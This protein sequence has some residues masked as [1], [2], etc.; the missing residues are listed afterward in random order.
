MLRVRMI[1]FGLVFAGIASAQ[2]DIAACMIVNNSGSYRL[3]SDLAS[4]DDCLTVSASNV[5]ID[6]N[7][8]SITGNCHVVILRCAGTA[9]TDGGIARRGV[10][11]RNGRLTNYVLG[12][13]LAASNAIRIENMDVI[14]MVSDAIDGGLY[15][16]VN[17]THALNNGLN[18]ISLGDNA[19]VTNSSANGNGST[20]ITVGANAIVTNSSANG[21]GYVTGT[22]TELIGHAGIVAGTGALISGNTANGNGFNNVFGV[23]GQGI[24]ALAGSQVTNNTSYGPGVSGSNA[25][26]GMVV[27]C[28]SNVVGNMTN[29]SISLRGTGCTTSNNN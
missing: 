15:T 13:N 4:A 10:T 21:N 23:N 24:I 1:F 6:L 28:P 9:I 11:I 26:V 16:S 22:G 8:F 3:T 25:F 17:N 20:G 27:F 19:I 5:T 29:N 14:G 18:G 7:G 12:I 2:V